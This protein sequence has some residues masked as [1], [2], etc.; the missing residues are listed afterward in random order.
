MKTTN[1]NARLIT[2]TFAIADEIAQQLLA[3]GAAAVFG[4]APM[5]QGLQQVTQLCP[6]IRS[7]ILL[8]PS[9][10][11]FVSFQ[12][13]VQDSGDMFNEHLNVREI[14]GQ[15]QTLSTTVYGQRTM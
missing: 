7:I 8:G 2:L 15:W 1:L 9:Q 10:E 13:M 4:V 3:L 11:G 6:S 14:L 12:Q 5:A